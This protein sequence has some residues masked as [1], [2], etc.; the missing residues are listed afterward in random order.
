MAKKKAPKKRVSLKGVSDEQL[1]EEFG[2]RMGKRVEKGGKEFGKGMERCFGEEGKKW[3]KECKS[4]FNAFGFFGP[5]IKSLFGLVC[6]I[7]LIAVFNFIDAGSPTPFISSLIAF[8][9]T[10]L[11]WLFLA[12]LVLEYAKFGLRLMGKKKWV[13]SPLVRG[14]EATYVLWILANIFVAINLVANAWLF[15]LVTSAI[16]GYTLWLFMALVLISYLAMMLGKAF[17]CGCCCE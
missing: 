6:L 13:L 12:S 1:F 8:F 17:R 2:E 5:L 11:P 4:A 9:S 7:I 10:Y 16:L 3:G 15:S 14:A